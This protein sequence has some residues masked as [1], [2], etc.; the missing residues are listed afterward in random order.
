MHKILLIGNNKLTDGKLADYLAEHGFDIVRSNNLARLPVVLRE[1]SAIIIENSKSSDSSFSSFIKDSRA[2][3]TIVID[4]NIPAKGI[5]RWLAG[6]MTYP[7]IKPTRRQIVFLLN[8][9]IKDK[10]LYEEYDTMQEKLVESEKELSLLEKFSKS[11]A[12]SLELHS[13][14]DSIMKNITEI[15]QAKKWSFYLFDEDFDK[16]HLEKTHKKSKSRGKKL[17]FKPGEGIVGWVAQEGVP[18]IIPDVRSDSHFCS[19]IKEGVIAAKKTFICVPLRSKGQI[20]GAIEVIDNKHNRPFSKYDLHIILKI[21]DYASLAIE[22][23][24]L[25]QK[26]AELAITDDLTKLFNSRY[27]NRTMETEI[28]RCERYSTSVSLIFMDVDHFK[29]VNDHYGHLIG[30]KL[31]VEMGQILIKGL[32]AI[33][34][35]SRYGGDEFVVVLPQTPPST[36][37]QIAERLRKLINRHV[38]LKGEGLNLK[39]TASF[40]IASYPESATSK[41]DLLRLADEAMYKVKN[42]TRDGVYTV[43]P[44]D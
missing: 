19:E 17:S 32:R 9:A 36:A 13:I 43:S 10:Q 28:S 33:D 1:V 26:M 2:I 8:K 4:F 18:V 29:D 22:S 31:L 42:R 24:L 5:D 39:L 40:G 3:P 37:T 30:S 12:T 25:Y 14:I 11:L 15:T 34:I 7:A 16:L 35:V 21:V 27:L 20:I 38:F 23:A 6:N 44:S 41:D